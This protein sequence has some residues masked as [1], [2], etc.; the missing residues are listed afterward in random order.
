MDMNFDRRKSLQE[1]EQDDWGEP[2]YNS[3]LVTTCHRLRRKPLRD[4]TLEDLRIMI[5]QKIS[6]TY[7]IPIALEQLE[8]D[9]LLSGDFYPGALLDR[10]IEI[11]SEYWRQHAELAPLLAAVVDAA[12]HNLQ[13][14]PELAS[15]TGILQRLQR[16]KT[17]PPRDQ[18]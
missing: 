13:L 15:G 18:Y 12:M 3:Y 4:F 5:G 17:D 2:T 14:R 8:V 1:L 11:P 10:I 9:P 7:L 6:L 16:F